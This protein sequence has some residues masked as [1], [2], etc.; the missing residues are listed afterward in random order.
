MTQNDDKITNKGCS[1]QQT[2]PFPIKAFE[3]TI[4]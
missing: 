1:S 3:A 2:I 4:L